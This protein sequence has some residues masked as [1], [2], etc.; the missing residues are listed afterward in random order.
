MFSLLRAPSIS[1]QNSGLHALGN[2]ISALGDPT[3]KTTHIPYRDS[4]LTRL[5]QDSLGGNAR[6]MMVACVSATEL[7]LNETLSTVKYANRARNI[8]NRAEINEVEVGWD[9]VDYLQRTI[10]KLRAEMASL[11]G[12]DVS[13]GAISEESNRRSIVGGE[14]NES[15][16]QRKY[17]ELTAELVTLKANASAAASTSLSR[18]EF[19]NAIEPVVEEYEKSLS[20]LESQLSLTRAALGHSEE[21]IRELEARVE[22]EVRANE[23]SGSLIDELKARVSKLGEREATV[24]AYVRDL[25]AKLKD[26]GEQ[27]ESHGTAVSDLR[28]EIT[29]NREQGEKTEQ[30]IVDLEARLAKSDELN[31]TLRRQIDVLERDVQRREEAYQELEGRLSLLDTSGDHKQL[32]A[33]I[34]EKDRRV[35]DL[36]RTLDELKSKTLVA[37]QEQERLEKLA[38]VEKEAKEELQSRVRTLERAS[39]VSVASRTRPDSFSSPQTPADGA[40]GDPIEESTSIPP[41]SARTSSSADAVVVAALE[42]QLAKLQQSHDAT[43]VELEAANVK[44]RNSLKEIED[45]N[46]QVSDAKIVNSNSEDGDSFSS[47]APSPVPSSPR[48]ERE[49]GLGL[50]EEE[51]VEELASPTSTSLSTPP[52]T[53]RT[54]RSRRSMPLAPQHRLSFLGRGQG[55]PAHTHARS[56]SLSQE[57]SLA[58]SQQASSPPNPRASSPS[59]GSLN[60]DSIYSTL[61]A[62]TGDRSYEQMKTEVMKL[63]SVLNEREA[64]IAALESTLHELRGTASTSPGL[65]PAT[66]RITRNGDITPPMIS[67][68]SPDLD[69]SLSPKTRAAFDAFKADL[70]ASNFP[71]SGDATQEDNAIR[72]DDLMRAMAKK[73]SAHREAVD[74]LQEQLDSLRR[75]HDELTVLSRD[76][77]VN[78][79]SEISQLRLALEARPEVSHYED[80]L[81]SMQEDLEAKGGEIMAS[82]KL[83][84]T[85]LSA[86]TSKLTEGE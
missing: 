7:N 8:K 74:E 36:E 33:E 25:E 1:L 40:D 49:R 70:S 22:E 27:D 23:A 85:D 31:S 26:Y 34:D 83:A 39:I 46:A 17:A 4:K 42:H 15:E 48:F 18:E 19:A 3:K 37:E 12:G 62:S 79:S 35:L 43:L 68:H 86:A 51:E 61:T 82:R 44:Y 77:V 73:E 57:L 29:K 84:E 55:A 14:G 6:T 47:T 21:E 28:K 5:L 53:M 69:L 78:M 80:K 50:G 38:A 24:E 59:P 67:P 72:L 71:G 65:S 2:V 30:Y 10:T 20:A 76:Q 9:D 13:L 11:K 60:R 66:P 41:S 58:V 64:E 54:P 75:Q 16:L 56:A 81:R 45:L 63:Q 32:L 52:P